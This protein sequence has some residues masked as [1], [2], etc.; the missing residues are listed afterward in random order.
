MYRMGILILG[1]DFD[2]CV[3]MLWFHFNRRVFL[4]W[5]KIMP[6]GGAAK[7]KNSIFFGFFNA[8]LQESNSNWCWTKK[9]SIPCIIIPA[10][11]SR[12]TTPLEYL[13]TIRWIF[14][15]RFIILGYDISVFRWK[16]PEQRTIKYLGGGN[17]LQL[18]LCIFF[19]ELFCLRIKGRQIRIEVLENCII[20]TIQGDS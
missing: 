19:T 20:H 7:R 11:C 9:I 6:F 3:C 10:N 13:I 2:Q 14:P 12:S 5:P 1:F 16:Y 8:L 4:F 18:D 15:A 17:R